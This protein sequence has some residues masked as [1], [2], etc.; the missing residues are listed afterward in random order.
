MIDGA[1]APCTR[2]SL[3]ETGR[4]RGTRREKERR[5][6]GAGSEADSSATAWEGAEA[7]RGEGREATE[8]VGRG[9][10]ET[11][12]R[13]DAEEGSDEGGRERAR[14]RGDSWMVV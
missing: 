2:A 13:G 5:M 3:A 1:V 4:L 9:I 8:A 14:G 12:G 11:L 7:V 10:L 6:E